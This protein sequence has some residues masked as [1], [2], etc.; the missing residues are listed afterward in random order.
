M[1]KTTF[2]FL[3]LPMA[4][5]LLGHGLIRLPKLQGFSTWMADFMQA[6]YLPE[7][8]ITIFSYSVPF[9][10]LITGLLLL[11]GIFTRVT[12]YLSLTLMALFIFGNTTIENWEAITS[13]LLHA[14]Y[15]GGLLICLERYNLKD[16]E[17][18]NLREK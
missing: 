3:R 11:A 2:F 6:S 4:L 14:A 5:S 12:L 18:F 7:F 9:I 10:E 16:L 17:L 15:L 1:K 8:L 13:E